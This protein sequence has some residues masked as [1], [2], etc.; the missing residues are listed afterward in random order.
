MS[1][2]SLAEEPARRVEV[3]AGVHIP[4]LTRAPSL[5][6]FVEARYPEEAMR[7]GLTADV[8]LLITVGADG[9]V[10]DATVKT[11]AG[12]GFDE[13]AVEAVKRF[14]FTPA[15]VDNTPASVQLEYV[16]HFVLRTPAPDA[17]APEE[18]IDAGPALSAHLKGSLIARGSRTRVP[19]AIVRCTNWEGPESVSDEP[20]QFDLQ[21][22]AGLCQVKVVAADF[23]PYSTTEELK[24]NETTEV[25]FFLLP[26]VQGFET[27]VRGEKEKKEVVSRTISR[28]EAEK[29][30]GTFGDPIRVVQNF[31]GVARAPFISGLLIVRGAQPGQTLTY[32]DGVEIPLLFHLLG[33]PSIINGDFL[34]SIDFLPGGFSSRYGRAIGGVVDVKSRK[35]AT[36]TVHGTVKVDLLDASIFLEAPLT[37]N[38]SIA[39]AVR[40]SYIDAILPAVLGLLKANTI[41]VLPVYWDYQLRLD[42]GL[43]RG[44]K[45]GVDGRSSWSVFAFGSDDQLAV[46]ATGNGGNRG[47]TVDYH[48]TFHRLE[49]NWTY[50]QGA[51]TFKVTPYLGLD[52]AKISLG[53]T[54]TFN[55]NEYAQGLRS[56]LDIDVKPWLT[57]HSGFDIYN[58]ELLGT[59][60]LP[61]L[62]GVQYPDFPGADVKAPTQTVSETLGFFDGAVYAE[63]DFKWGKL[64]VTPG[65]R[66]SHAFIDNQTRH[67]FD[68]RLWLK[69]QLLE[70]T[71]LKGSV[72]LY[73]QPPSSI[74]MVSAPFGTPSLGYERAFQSSLGVAHR[75]TENI[76]VDVTGFFNRRFE[77]IVSPG[78]TVVNADGSLAQAQAANAGLGKAFGVEVLAR[79]E[80]TK[81]LFGWL[82]Y[83]FSRSVERTAGTANDYVLSQ[84]DQTHILTAIAS[85][86]FDSGWEVGA[87]FRYVTGNPLTPLTHP[88]DEYG[89]DSNSY[90]RQTGAPRSARQPAFNQ[91]DIRVDKYFTFEKWTLDLYADVQNVYNAQNVEATFYDYRFRQSYNVPGIPILPVIGA[92]ATF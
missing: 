11:P 81:H 30:P 67:A 61:S 65:L 91:L 62:G 60:T 40:R 2:L 76:N 64:T 31:P 19:G 79:H 57:L 82:A 27:V 73:T 35:G 37:E 5:L 4:V 75:F 88:Y 33:G 20:G 17:G 78:P 92:K 63:A 56:D 9:S 90:F 18:A 44:Q 13:A 49:A 8:H 45:E 68:P 54:A 6:Q 71:T 42:G 77:N 28:E 39:G 50:H 69:Y 55:V 12:S 14:S 52:V 59:G 84:Y 53:S 1:G 36:D 38:V 3:D 86:R 34:D 32:M 87:R 25:N 85:Y 22:P 72:G 26:K 43:K 23:K 29:S 24:E 10:A 16:Y 41:S 7:A 66:A 48:T 70:H 74:A 21:V 80:V 83:T 15:E 47:V 46:A 51:T 58:V 89:V